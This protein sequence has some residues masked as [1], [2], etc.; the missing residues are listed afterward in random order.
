MLHQEYQILIM[1]IKNSFI[2]IGAI[3]LAFLMPIIPLMLIVGA[4]IMFDTAFGIAR[5]YKLKEKITSRKM[6]QLISKMCIYQ[7]ALIG[8][9][10]IE[11]FILGDIVAMFISV[12]LFLT[13]MTAATLLFIEVTSVN[14]NLKAGFKIDLWGKFKLMLTRAKQVKKEFEEFKN[15]ESNI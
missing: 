11:H 9:Y 5:A 7:I 1:N 2:T 15:D 6:S 8:V 13:K 3:V 4:A 12:P 14:E 10:V